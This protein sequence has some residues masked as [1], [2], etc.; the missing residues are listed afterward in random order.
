MVGVRVVVCC[1]VVCCVVALPLGMKIN[2]ICPTHVRA[3]GRT[4]CT[5]EPRSRPAEHA[6]FRERRGFG[7]RGLA[8]RQA[9]RAPMCARYMWGTLAARDE[10]KMPRMAVWSET[11]VRVADLDG[12]EIEHAVPYAALGL[13]LVG[14][15][16]HG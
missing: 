4:G 1:V 7:E 2:R 13:R 15:G 5:R 14:K 3:P 8:F 10:V 11:I 16:A 12:H 9:A 6:G